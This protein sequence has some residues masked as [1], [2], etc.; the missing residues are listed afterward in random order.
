MAI[1]FPTS[2]DYLKITSGFPSL[3]AYTIS[4]WFKCFSFNASTGY[5]FSRGDVA[6]GGVPDRLFLGS[7][8]TS[9]PA[10]ALTVSTSV[11]PSWHDGPTPAPTATWFWAALAKNGTADFNLYYNGLLVNGPFTSFDPTSDVL[12]LATGFSGGVPGT[13]HAPDSAAAGLKMWEAKLS[14][15]ELLKEFSSYAAIRATN[16]YAVW[17]LTAA[18]D[19]NDVSGNAHHWASGGTPTTVDGPTTRGTP[20]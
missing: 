3:T 9:A 1:R 15:D 14:A 8:P 2:A 17:P 18:G 4:G 6:L 7:N 19:L 20:R 5:L 12:A 11:D 16:L 10:N 13:T